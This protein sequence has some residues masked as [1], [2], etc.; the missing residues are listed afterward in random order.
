MAVRH[1][2]ARGRRS[3]SSCSP[4]FI[5]RELNADQPLIDV[6]IFANRAFSAASASVT[7]TF[8]SLFGALF[9]LT[10]YL[11][12]VKGYGT[13]D[14]GLAALPFAAACSSPPR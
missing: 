12:L 9:A 5:V 14:A 10:Q 7:I 6:R 1:D 2:P 4:A 11:Q 13:L 3:A 8:F